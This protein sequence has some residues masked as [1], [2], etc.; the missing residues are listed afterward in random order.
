[1]KDHHQ[2]EFSGPPSPQ[3]EGLKIRIVTSQKGAKAPRKPRPMFIAQLPESIRYES[4]E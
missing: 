1:M 4:A 2:H 3:P